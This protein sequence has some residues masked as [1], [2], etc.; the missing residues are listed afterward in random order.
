[1]VTTL[2][3]LASHLQIT[4]FSN[5][6]YITHRRPLVLNGPVMGFLR[7]LFLG[8]IIPL[9][10]CFLMVSVQLFCSE[11]LDLTFSGSVLVAGSNPNADYIDSGI[12]YPTEYRLEKFHPAYFKVRRPSPTGIPNSLRYGG[13]FFN[14]SLSS[15]D[16]FHHVVNV[17]LSKVVVMR[18]GFSTHTMVSTD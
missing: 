16:L 18:T 6:L 17:K 12:P 14:L 9:L 8:C 10:L 2:G 4:L 11:Q 5:R 7:V 3:L 15:D 1:M 13:P